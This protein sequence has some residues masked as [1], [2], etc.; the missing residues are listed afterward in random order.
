MADT[1]LDHRLARSGPHF[2]DPCRSDSPGWIRQQFPAGPTGDADVVQLMVQWGLTTWGVT[3]PDLTH[4][5]WGFFLLYTPQHT[6]GHLLWHADSAAQSLSAVNGEVF[7]VR[8][9]Q[10]PYWQHPL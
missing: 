7:L 5:G 9:A 2:V 3:D 10:D 4:L 8:V 6:L 1:P